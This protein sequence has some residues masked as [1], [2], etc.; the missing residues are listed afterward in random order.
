[1]ELLCTVQLY[2]WRSQSFV[3]IYGNVRMCS[4]G[5]LEACCSE[6]HEDNLFKVP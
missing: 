5:P 4:P 2:L 1:M 6:A 3:L